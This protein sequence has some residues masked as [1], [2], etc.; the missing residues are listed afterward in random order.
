M[1]V[2]TMPAA[3][4]VALPLLVARDA[5]ATDCGGTA[6]T[7]INDDILWPH[8]GA[9]QFVAIGSTETL[10]PRQVGFGLV[11]SYLNRPIILHVQSPGPGS[12]QYA[13]NDQVNGTFP[14]EPYR[15]RRPP[16]A[17]PR[18]ASSR[19]ARAA[20]A[21]PPSRAASA[22]RTRP[23]ATCA[24]A[25]RTRSSPTSPE[26]RAGHADLRRRGHRLEVSAPTGDSDQFAGDGAGVFAPSLAADWRRRRFF[27]GAEVGARLR[28]T[29]QLASG[30]IGPEL[31]TALGVGYDVWPQRH[32]AATLEAWAL[33]DLVR[34]ATIGAGN[35][36]TPTSAT[37]VPA[38][39]QLGARWAPLPGGDVSIDVSGGGGLPIGADDRVTTPRFRFTLGIR[40]A[41]L[42]HDADGDG[43]PDSADRCPSVPAHTADGCPPAPE[44]PPAGE[45]SPKPDLRA[46][47]P[48]A[49]G[50]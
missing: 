41:P 22:S 13:I 21:S 39:W 36:S 38:E 37:I 24:S 47:S 48:P 18:G 45:P 46:P 33:P 7:C 26:D 35:V 19:S 27:A 50:P 8:A 29:S 40:W 20:R 12:D 43:V 25:S 17:R 15:R 1:R 16:R 30:R 23:C 5:R 6:S 28:R 4:A 10:A 14:L 44:E 9:S 49:P 11:T 42:G 2:W 3:A 34:Q 31:V 32:V